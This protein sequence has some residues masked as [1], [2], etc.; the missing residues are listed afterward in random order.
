MGRRSSPLSY[1]ARRA[2]S[3]DEVALFVV[4]PL[5]H[6]D[7]ATRIATASWIAVV[8]ITKLL[9]PIGLVSDYGH[10]VFDLHGFGD[11]RAWI[12]LTTILALLAT[13]IAL[14]RSA[15]GRACGLGIL[16]LLGFGFV[17]SN[18][19]FASGTIFGE[20]L[21]F[22]PSLGLAIATAW[23]LDAWPRR[24]P[25]LAAGAW[26]LFCLFSFATRIPDWKDNAS[27][28]AHDAAT[29]PRSARLQLAASDFA[30][31][32]EKQRLIEAALSAWP[33]YPN[34]V[35]ALGN[36]A[37]KTN[38]T[39]TGRKHLYRALELEHFDE[40]RDGFEVRWN[41][42]GSE[43]ANGSLDRARD[44]ITALVAKHQQEF[45]ANFG[46]IESIT[47]FLRQ[48]QQTPRAR[49]IWRMIANHPSLPTPARNEAK[50][51]ANR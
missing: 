2:V 22:A 37:L 40:T 14:L 41:L 47:R 31:G 19:P 7:A 42:L 23:L 29:Q 8:A 35:I 10:A 39:D 49:A 24:I 13:G 50:R 15:R 17:T 18:V 3:S 46:Q 4:N 9:L 43:L 33:E 25:L 30:T 32:A 26:T 20:R 38:Q 16:A 6:S 28:F 12:G 27:L 21:L 45:A 11:A 51:R 36:L 48:R 5:A 44:L 34:A 1:C